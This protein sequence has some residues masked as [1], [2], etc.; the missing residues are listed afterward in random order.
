MSPTTEQEILQ[1]LQ[2]LEKTTSV[3]S[4][5]LFGEEDGENQE[6]RLPRLEI[7]GRDHGQRIEQLEHH[8]IKTLAIGAVLMGVLELA[9]HFI[10]FGR[11]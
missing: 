11:H 1:S 8:Q 3:I 7:Q 10:P 5:K 9:I 6:G 4:I 2:K